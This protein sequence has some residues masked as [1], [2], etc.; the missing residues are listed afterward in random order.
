MRTT[1]FKA[2][3]LATAAL[4]SQ[5]V[6]AQTIGEATRGAVV[7]RPK[8]ATEPIVL[9]RKSYALVIG[10]DNYQSWPKL[11]NA[12]KDA[13]AVK[14][15][16]EKLDFEVK[17]VSDLSR[18]R[19]VATLEEWF[20]FAGMEEDTRLLVWF[21]GHGHTIE[22]PGQE[23][24]GYI[25]GTDA[26]R[27]PG[28]AILPKSE[29]EFAR[30]ALPM[31][32]FGELVREAYSRHVLVVLN[33]C[34]S[35]TVFSANRSGAPPPL[36]SSM[37]SLPVRQFI[38]SGTAGQSVRDDGMF[39]R[40]FISAVTGQEP[41]ADADKDGY[42]TGTELGL[43]LQSKMV[44]L[45]NNRQKPVYGPLRETGFDRGDFVFSL[46]REAVPPVPAPL[47][48]DN[49]DEAFWLFIRDEKNAGLT[50]R[51][52]SR[53]PETPFRSSA[54]EHAARLRG[55]VVKGVP[56]AVSPVLPSR[57]FNS[58]EIYFG[59][60]RR[61]DDK[62]S[63]VGFAGERAGRLA[64][65]RAVVSVP[66]QRERGSLTRPTSRLLVYTAAEDPTRDFTLR[67][68]EMQTR[69]VMAGAVRAQ[70]AAGPRSRQA[71]VFVH[72]YNM[73]FDDT[74]YRAAQLATDTDFAGPVFVYAWPS[75]G[76]VSDYMY[77]REF[78]QAAEPHFRE[79]LETLSRDL[80]L[81]RVHLL[82]HSTG[83]QLI[84][85][86][87]QAI[88]S[89]PKNIPFGE[90]IAAAP[91]L[92][93]ELFDIGCNAIK[94]LVRG[95]TVYASNND[96][97]LQASSR[98]SAGQSRAGEIGRNGPTISPCADVIDTSALA[99]DQF[100]TNHSAFAERG[101]LLGDM[102][103]LLQSGQRP[104]HSRTAQLESVIGT[105]GAYWRFAR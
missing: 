23:P 20:R 97:A 8:G 10:N 17:L 64:L 21:A 36:I 11:T 65:G 82:G 12:V 35:G 28:V 52:V 16:L 89:N 96:R 49:K 93:S 72:G 2:M 32:R 48:P 78:V 79:F 67:S 101:D 61:Q 33:S 102:S 31:S 9:Y 57:P 27:A 22:R 40:L 26:G 60:D 105:R 90:Y 103:R 58:V 73:T 13:E 30:G 95:I 1:F 29:V 59:T 41:D 80:G 87:L 77:D 98:I 63:R 46:K 39:R 104:P 7:L 6:A 38:T 47:P 42:V 54:E 99:S 66:K 74:L 43:F 25:V 76:R 18:D 34:F 15:A 85:N 45:S 71:L 88:G 50:D 91:D 24:R 94:S 84:M 5:P 53:F 68:I 86:T 69:D 37:T 3:L 62:A 92:T 100:S 83:N 4:L 81:E 55:D 70:M 75:S 19:L 56:P 51:F 44:N 14:E